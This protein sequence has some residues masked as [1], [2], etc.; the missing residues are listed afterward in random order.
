MASTFGL[1]PIQRRYIM[2]S[3]RHQRQSGFTLIELIIVIVIIGILAAVAIPKF[4]SLTTDAQL[5]STQGIAGALSSADGANFA[6][7]SGFPTK[8][9]P[10]SNCTDVGNALQGGLP[11]GYTITAA[12]SN[13]TGATCTL[14][15]PGGQAATFIATSV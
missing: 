3:F 5:A 8:G 13:P 9:V 10:V 7:R 1:R 2:R 6:I 11:G 14:T 4:T 15:G 12:S